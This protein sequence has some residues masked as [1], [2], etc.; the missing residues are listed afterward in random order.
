MG[1]TRVAIFSGHLDPGHVACLRAVAAAYEAVGAAPGVPTW[2]SNPYVEH[3]RNNAR[4][5]CI[6][7]H[8][9]GGAT[10]A[11]DRDGDGT[12]DPFD[13]DRVIDDDVFFPQAGRP[14]QRDVFIADYLYSFNRV[15][16]FSGVIR[17]EVDFFEHV[18]ADAVAPRIRAIQA[19]TGDADVGAMTFAENCVRC[20]GADGTGT[21]RA[22]SLYERVPM[23]ADESILRTLI[24][25]RG[26]MPVWGDAFDDPTLASILAFLR[27]TF[28]A[29]PERRRRPLRSSTLRTGL[30]VMST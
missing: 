4:T 14:Q 21:E 1:F 23:R 30:V 6:G 5:N 11:H 10:V 7:C 8:Q 25:G 18:D 13:L 29:P 9:H 24:Q 19:L 28:G 20:H 17:R 16:D 3:G 2:C 27:A 15:D 12:P 26:N 22:P